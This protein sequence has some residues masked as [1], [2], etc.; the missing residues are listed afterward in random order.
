MEFAISFMICSELKCGFI[1]V[2]SFFF[3]FDVAI[4][5]CI[6]TQKFWEIQ[7]GN[8][9]ISWRNCISL[10]KKRFWSIINAISFFRRNEMYNSK[11]IA[12]CTW[13]LYVKAEKLVFQVNE[14]ERSSKIRRVLSHASPGVYIL[15]NMRATAKQTQDNRRVFFLY[16]FLAE[17]HA[18]GINEE[19]YHRNHD[20]RKDRKEFL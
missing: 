12:P 8:F 15:W 9:N 5:L 17:H 10:T 11:A 20:N 18:A 16:A 1:L 14:V 3:G 13:E 2:V 6:L 7:S 4:Q 19:A